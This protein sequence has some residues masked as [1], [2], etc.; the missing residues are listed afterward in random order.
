M[1][2]QP[3]RWRQNSAVFDQ[4]ADEY[5]S[6][7]DD[8]LLFAIELDALTSLAT[9]LAAPKLEIGV[10]PGRFAAALGAN[11]GLDPALAPLH[12]AA[13]RGIVPAQAIGE[14]LPIMAGSTGTVFLL[15]TLCFVAEPLRVLRECGRILRPGGNL[16][17]GIIPAQSPWG[18]H[19]AAK[20]KAGNP[21]YR[22][23]RFRDPETVQTWLDASG[24][25][26]RECRSSLRQPPEALAAFEPSQP[27]ITPEAGFVVIVAGKNA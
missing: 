3:P 12:L 4:R 16:V 15:F 8:S 18:L 25:A 6:W 19:L 10:G 17:A 13:S 27:G 24:F 23:A 9:P 5:D 2:D 22:H 11:F 7:F 20:G 1:P 21:Y 26:I 14:E